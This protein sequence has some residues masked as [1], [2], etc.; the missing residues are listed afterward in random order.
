VSRG[1][2]PWAALA[3]TLAFGPAAALPRADLA[4]VLAAD[5][6]FSIDRA[7]TEIQRLGY[8]A[9]FRSPDLAR[10]VARGPTGRIAVTYVEWSGPETQRQILPWQVLETPADLAAFAAA[11][12][13]APRGAGDSTSISAGLGVA[14]ALFAEAPVAPARWVVDLS[15]DG[16]N[17]AGP[18][19]AQMQALAETAGITINGLPILD[20]AAMELPVDLVAY[21]EACVKAGP[22]A[23]V[24]PV[25]GWV[26]FEA[27]LLRKLTLEITGRMPERVFRAAGPRTDC[28][29]GEKLERDQYLQQLEAIT[30]GRAERWRPRDEDW[31]V[32][33]A[34]PDK[35]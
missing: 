29:I 19:L 2:L 21:F 32:P 31:Q 14:L 3:L 23:F 5:T 22:G 24:M 34:R 35:P 1:P 4:L 9:A 6:S 11:L 26:D 13:Q 25:R 20:A 10:A 28:L 12:E 7:E 18:P 17:N 27:T 33:G 16:I 15:S 30:G 8:A